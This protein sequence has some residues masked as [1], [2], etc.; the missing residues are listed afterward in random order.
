MIHTAGPAKLFAAAALALAVLSSCA[1]ETAATATS[2]GALDIY[3]QLADLGALARACD[4]RAPDVVTREW[5]R[6]YSRREQ[7][8]SA[9]LTTIY[10]EAAV[11]SA[12]MIS[13]HGC[14]GG[15]SRSHRRQYDAAL[16]KLERRLDR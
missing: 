7:A 14:F 15:S 4:G 10:G 16:E 6:R 1:T 9:R 12:Q 2:E 5:N 8:L 11:E 13:V 3:A